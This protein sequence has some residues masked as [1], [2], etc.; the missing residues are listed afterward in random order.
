VEN[1]FGDPQTILLLGATS[2]LGQA[3]VAR[4]VTPSLTTVVLA[5]RRPEDAAPFA[6][7]L[8]AGGLGVETV[9]F[10]AVDHAHHGA[11]VDDVWARHG[12]I[13]LVV[14]AFGVLGDPSTYDRDPVAAAEVVDVNMTG[15]VSAGVALARHLREQGHGRLVVLSS[16]AGERVRKGNAVYG[17]AKAG[18]DAFAQALADALAPAGVAVTI[19]RPGFVA[20]KMTAG[21]RP[22]P[23]ATTVDAVADATLVAVR[24]GRRIVWVPAVL[25]PV[26]VVLRH[27]PTPIWRRLAL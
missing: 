20:T 8:R 3:I 22:A 16:V 24:K 2:E 5:G 21:L 27:L 7:T 19:V 6:A 13:D 23:F 10:D 18:L 11:L 26:F 14:M 12:D 4:F 9:A 1:A 17:A 25:R 15:G